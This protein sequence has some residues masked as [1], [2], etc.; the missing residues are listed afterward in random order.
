MVM[1]M[2]KLKKLFVRRGFELIEGMN[3]EL[4]VKATIH[5]AG[6]DFIASADIVIP[7]FRFKST[8]TLVPTG[9]KAF[10]PKNEC[11]L[12]FA[13]S[14]LPVNHGLIMSNGVG[15]RI[16]PYVKDKF[17]KEYETH[18]LFEVLGVYFTKAAKALKELQLKEE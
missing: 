16:E 7:A 8:A 14:S 10:M 6:V 3:G 4:P 15:V 17:P 12:I 2:N 11:L 5:S 18:E 1:K 13:R 9:I